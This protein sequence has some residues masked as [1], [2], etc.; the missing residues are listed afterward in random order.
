VPKHT[1]GTVGTY[2]MNQPRLPMPNRLNALYDAFALTGFPTGLQVGMDKSVPDSTKLYGW[3]NSPKASD[4]A[5]TLNNKGTHTALAHS[6][7]TWTATGKPFLKRQKSIA[8]TKYNNVLLAQMISLKL[9]IAASSMEM[10]P[11]GFGELI[12]DDASLVPP[13]G[14]PVLNG[15]MVKEVASL[16]DSMMMG[17]AHVDTIIKTKP[18]YSRHFHDPAI[19]AYLNTAV[20]KINNAFEGQ[21]DTTSFSSVLTFTG[22]KKL[23]DVSYLKGN[24]SVVPAK[25]IP[26]Y[27][28]LEQIPEA[29]KL[30][31]NYPNP[32]NPT[33][34]IQ[35]DLPEE[36]FVTLKVYNL[37][38]QEVATLFNHEQMTEGTQEVE[39]SASSFA[40]GVYFYRLSAEGIGEEGTT[41]ST[42]N[43]VHKMILMK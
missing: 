12:Y 5:K 34:M 6:F 38:G 39:F 7:D 11:L 28:K 40:S 33:T 20:T 43:S 41:S 9:N 26:D 17:W 13:T 15:M 4:V 30:H 21:L 2:I 35:F 14:A 3:L 1:K 25:I 23:I 19:M 24:S 36:A 32:F 37:L 22:V 10:I 16:V 29:Y 18:V 8:P 42:F 27:T 31:Q